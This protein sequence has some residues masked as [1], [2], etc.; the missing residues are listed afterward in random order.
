MSGPRVVRNDWSALSRVPLG[1]WAPT[2]SV[3]VVIPAYQAHRTLPYTLAA[4]RAQTYPAHLLEVIVVDDGSSPP[5]V[6]PSDRPENTRLVPAR[7]SW[8]R[9]NACR[10]GA[11]AATGQVLHWLDADMVPAPDE[12]EAQMRWHHQIDH[13]VVLGHKWIIDDADLPPVDRLSA[14]AETDTLGDLF[15]DR[16]AE[17][18]SWVEA[19]WGSSHDLQ[20]SGFRAFH[21]HVGATASVG[22]DLYEAAGGMDEQLRLGEDIELGYRLTQKG[23]VF[24][25]D[26]EARN[27]HLG[28]TT[29]MQHEDRVRRYNNPFIADRVPDLRRLREKRGR[30]Y[31]VPLAEVVVTAEGHA[32]EDVKFTLDAALKA[33]PGD[34]TCVLVGP[35]S[36]LSRERHSPLGDESLDLRLMQAEYTSEPRV[37]FVEELAPTA[38]PAMYRVHLPVGW[39]AGQALRTVLRDMQ[40]QGHGLRSV[41]LPD[42][43][44]ARFEL[45]AAYER[46]S[47]LVAESEDIDDVVDAIS[48]SWWSEGV[49]LGFR[50]ASPLK[51]PKAA[52]TAAAPA[53]LVQHDSV[54]ASRWST[55]A[56]GL[57]S[58]RRNRP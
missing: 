46:A 32:F 19:V 1:Q 52:P 47:R 3:S 5:L 45:T 16:W 40:E 39:R 56:R 14:A 13:A 49:E 23:A 48:G 50:D 51:E 44:V 37:R 30:C 36:K 2:M 57:R 17:P 41:L 6:L 7:H 31:R 22:R 28:G 42:G 18:H 34:T 27:W 8:G 4:L 53:P 9:A 54:P 24:I 29:V 58:P 43:R 10:E 12:V 25:A 33:E 38:F 21:V 15:G 20:R 11:Q 55:L 35:W 26:R